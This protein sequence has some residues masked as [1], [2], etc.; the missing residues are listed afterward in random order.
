L[1]RP[2]GFQPWIDSQPPALL[3]MPRGD[4]FNLCPERF[5]IAAGFGGNVTFTKANQLSVHWMS[6]KAKPGGVRFG[7][8]LRPAGRD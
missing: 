5:G 3:L 8:K 4:P 1:L 6:P 2:F 7:V